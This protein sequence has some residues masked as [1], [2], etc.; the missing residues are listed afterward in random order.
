MTLASWYITDSAVERYHHA[1]RWRAH[2]AARARA[3]LSALAET[4]TFRGRDRHGREL[5]R[6]SKRLGRGLRWVLGPPQ[7]PDT[8]PRVL[9]VGHGVPPESVW[10]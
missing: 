4:A 10:G 7:P 8:R 5:W 1:M 9:W 3:E 6:S 2:D